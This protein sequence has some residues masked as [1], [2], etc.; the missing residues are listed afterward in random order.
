MTQKKTRFRKIPPAE[1][2][3]AVL[4]IEWKIAHVCVASDANHGSWRHT[5]TAVI[6]HN[7]QNI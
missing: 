2:H 1:C 3:C 7:R 4:E 6:I 5:N